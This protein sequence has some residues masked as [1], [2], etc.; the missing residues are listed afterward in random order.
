MAK[1]EKQHVRPENYFIT[2]GWMSTML[3]LKGLEKEIFAIIY[4]FSQTT[5]QDFTGSQEYI[6]E[7][8]GSTA[9]GVRKCLDKLIEKGYIIRTA[10]IYNKPAYS[11]RTLDELTQIC[12]IEE[13]G[14]PV[15]NTVESVEI[16]GKLSTN[17]EQ[18][19][20]DI[21]STSGTEF[22]TM[23]NG[24]PNDEE[25]CSTNE[26][27]CSTTHNNI[28]YNI[29]N[30]YNNINAMQGNASE[31]FQQ[32]EKE[33]VETPEKT[34]DGKY[35]Y[36]SYQ[37]II[38]EYTSDEKLQKRIWNFISMRKMLK[39]SLTNEGLALVLKNLDSVAGN[40]QEKILVLEQSIANSYADVYP[41]KKSREQIIKKQQE[42]KTKDNSLDKYME[43]VKKYGD[44]Y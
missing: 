19:S 35:R 21:N 39:K 13:C 32:Q 5:N 17:E 14:K 18:S 43:L 40:D 4:G 41:L 36:K 22:H 15:E 23:R 28:L 6:A 16:S 11:S 38:S 29:N 9:R 37:D 12:A 27:L 31:N 34:K 33:N 20:S 1:R 44:C 30:I 2:T 10:D 26:E 24:V 3:H 42:E 8:T 7:F 25:L